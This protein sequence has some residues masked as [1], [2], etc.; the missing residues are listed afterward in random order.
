MSRFPSLLVMLVLVHLTAGTVAPAATIEAT[1]RFTRAA[2]PAVLLWLP[3]TGPWKPAAEV[4]PTKVEQ[5]AE[6]FKPT[7]AVVQPGGTVAFH[8]GDPQQHNVF[9]LDATL[10]IDTDLG[11]GAPDSTLTLTTS[12][13]AGSVVKHG[14]KIHPQM[15]LWI[16]VL[17]TP[18]YTVSDIPDGTLE[19]MMRVTHPPSTTPALLTSATLWAPRCET[20]TVKIPSE[21]TPI[22]RKGKTVGTLSVRELP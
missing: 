6:T 3:E 2:P 4:G 19:V 13:P 14:C 16:A 5:L 15:Q 9:A 12:W 10:G 17:D 1:V 7:I 21:L 22:I 18:W 8:N 20:L 11:L